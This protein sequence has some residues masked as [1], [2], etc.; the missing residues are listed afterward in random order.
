MLR[1]EAQIEIAALH[2]AFYLASWGMYRG[3]S[4]LLWK[5]YK[6]HNDAVRELLDP[7]YT[8]LWNLRFD[9]IAKDTKIAKDI[10]SLSKKL[11]RTYRQRIKKVNGKSRRFNASD[12]L[13]TKILLGTLGC[14]PACD[15]YFIKGFR[16]ELSYSL[17]NERFLCRIFEFYRENRNEFRTVQDSISKNSG[18][19]YPIMKLFDMYFWEIGSKS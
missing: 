15:Q 6:I 9:D 16:K 1:S 3:S 4:A 2:L 13:I 5:D 10:L 8:H 17:F 12:I 7:A 19:K 14:V 18:V 11:T